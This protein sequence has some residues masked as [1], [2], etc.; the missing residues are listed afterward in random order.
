MFATA[1]DVMRV[2]DAFVR[3]EGKGNFDVLILVGQVATKLTRIKKTAFYFSKG[4]IRR[5]GGAGSISPL[6]PCLA[7]C[8]V[9]L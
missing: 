2:C 6:R 4:R 3:V 1:I 9:N 5:D 8:R 7:G